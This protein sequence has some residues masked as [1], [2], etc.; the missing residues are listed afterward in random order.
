MTDDL[1]NRI[2]WYNKHNERIMIQDAK[3][4][5]DR[6]KKLEAALREVVE[7]WDWWQVDTYDRCESV[8]ADAIRNARTVLAEENE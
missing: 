7:C 3:A 1:V 8:P 2:D 5:V 4:A 6:I